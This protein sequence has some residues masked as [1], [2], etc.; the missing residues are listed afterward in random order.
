MLEHI[1]KSIKII[2][3]VN[4]DISIEVLAGDFSGQL[5]PL[6]N[7]VD[8]SLQVF[9]HNIETV[10]RLTPRVRDNRAS[11]QQ[12]LEVLRV[13]KRECKNKIYT[14]T[15]LMLGFDEKRSE[16]LETLEDILKQDVDIITFGQY[17]RPTKKHLSVKRWVHPEEFK[18]LEAIAYKMGFKG[19]VS[20]P[21][22]RSS[23]LAGELYDSVQKRLI[24]K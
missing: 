1:C 21:L 8:C 9:A 15:S 4:K 19:V 2:Q 22:V 3:Q 24:N 10:K 13:A 11:Y 14:K 18:E 20:G 23:Y 16:V 5:L 6:K 7:I 12:S 17:M